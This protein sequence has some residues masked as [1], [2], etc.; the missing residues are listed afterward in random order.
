MYKF[1][2]GLIIG[3]VATVVIFWAFDISF[4]APEAQLPVNGNT[5]QMAHDE[6]LPADSLVGVWRSDE[7]A[8]FVRTIYE[9][10]GYTDTYE[11]EESATTSG[12]WVTFTKETAPEGLP[13]PLEEGVTYLQLDT[14][15]DA[16]YFAIF[17]NT[18]TKLVLNYLDRGNTLAFTR[19]TE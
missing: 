12:P 8:K 18:E 15:K 4:K 5:E 7:D 6:P 3:V 9:N 19:V 13:Y 17:E 1:L 16:L 2:L 10:G 11:G 14:G